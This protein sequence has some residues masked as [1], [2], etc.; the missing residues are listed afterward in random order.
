MA[1]R[2]TEKVDVAVVGA[3]GAGY[4]GAFLLDRAGLKVAMIDPIG[5]LGGDCLAEGCV[6]SKAVREAALTYQRLRGGPLSA[7][8]SGAQVD[9]SA[10]S[11]GATWRSILKHKDAVQQVRYEQHRRELASSGVNFVTGRARVVSEGELDVATASG[12]AERLTFEHLVLATGSAPSRLAVPGAELAVTSHDLFRLGADID[13]PE[14]PVIVG[15]GYIGMEVATILEH[16]GAT[17]VV[18]ELTDQVL[19][20]FDP[21]LSA[22]LERSLSGRVRL[23][24]GKA[25]TGIE[26]AGSDFDVRYRDR[27]ATGTDTSAAD[28]PGSGAV[29][30]DLVIMA[31]GRVPVLPEGAEQLGAE[32]RR[33]A[34]GVDAGLRTTN[35]SVWAPGDVNGT[36]MLFHSA[37]R[38]SVV[39]AHNIAAGGVIADRMDFASVPFTVFTDP[40][41]A[42]VGLTA[43]QA[44]ER[45]GD[46]AVGAYDYALDA[47][48]QILGET[49][50]YLRLIFDAHSA[51][52]VGAQVAGVDAA[53][54]IAPLALALRA[55]LG[56]RELAETA[57]P[58]P[59]ISEG[60]TNA[61]R[62]ILT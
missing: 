58:H 14:R 4:P 23:M 34:P 48:A 54:L 47:R 12:R 1:D 62:Q 36:S 22:F 37:V 41:L 21:D 13:L 44:A 30:G 42:G 56:A 26:R 5:N 9:T 49:S 28:G 16:L 31:T 2:V 60:I 15:G 40:E 24:L 45:L 29:R 3:G 11:A 27:P 39:V 19:P 46:I 10:G 51:R 59:M 25:V 38:Q 6:P 8:L 35:P 18:L 55:G 57:F 33:H 61:A 43:A 32:L 17:P 20:G 52:L 53:Q 7:L 50:G